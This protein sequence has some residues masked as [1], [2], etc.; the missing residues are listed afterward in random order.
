M[1]GACQRFGGD[2]ESAGTAQDDPGKGSW[3]FLGLSAAAGG[4]QSSEM[5]NIHTPFYIIL[6]I[7]ALLSLRNGAAAGK[8]P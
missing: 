8:I 4:S 6:I 7:G 5:L 3:W 2:T 1:I